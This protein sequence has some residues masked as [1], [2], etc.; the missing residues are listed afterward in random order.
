MI[1]NSAHG[2]VIRHCF[3]YAHTAVYLQENRLQQTLERVAVP[4]FRKQSRHTV[5]SLWPQ[6]KKGPS[7][8]LAG[9]HCSRSFSTSRLTKANDVDSVMHVASEM[10]S[11][12]ALLSEQVSL[13][14]IMIQNIC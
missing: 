14:S 2:F 6:F 9:V 11:D 13:V 4:V 8:L 7:T 5:N 3:R 1:L 10:G 12:L